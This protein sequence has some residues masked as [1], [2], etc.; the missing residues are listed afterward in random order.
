MYIT[1]EERAEHILLG[2]RNQVAVING[3]IEVIDGDKQDR[4]CRGT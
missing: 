1:P 3:L 4:E 2:G